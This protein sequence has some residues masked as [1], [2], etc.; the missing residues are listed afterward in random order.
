V[1]LFAFLN[2]SEKRQVA[3]YSAT[4]TPKTEGLAKMSLRDPM[5]VAV[6]DQRQHATVEGLEQVSQFSCLLMFLDCKRRGL[7]MS[8]SWPIKQ[9]TGLCM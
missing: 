5:Y 9:S 2:F 1:I 7:E 8:V 6:D 3:M 4:L